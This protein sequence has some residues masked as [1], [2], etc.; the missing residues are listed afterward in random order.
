MVIFNCHN[1]HQIQVV[2]NV[3]SYSRINKSKKVNK[4]IERVVIRVLLEILLCSKEVIWGVKT[5][6]SWKI[7]I[8]LP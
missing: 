6:Y 4:I 3:Y 2:I 8:S 1:Y 5:K 7:Q